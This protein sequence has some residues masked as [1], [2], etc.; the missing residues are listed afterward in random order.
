MTSLKELRHIEM[1]FMQLL[2][3]P[4]YVIF[5]RK[6]IKPLFAKSHKRK[7]RLCIMLIFINA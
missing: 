2:N 7:G 3:S 4:N 6:D 5:A 1:E